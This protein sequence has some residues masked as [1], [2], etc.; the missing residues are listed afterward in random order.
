MLSNRVI[1]VCMGLLVGAAV[2]SCS[3]ALGPD[4]WSPKTYRLELSRY[5]R[6]TGALS[7]AWKK[8]QVKGQ[9][10]DSFFFAHESEKAVVTVVFTCGKYRDVPL[11]ILAEELAIP[12]GRKPEIIRAGFVRR[13]PREVYRLVARGPY[14][15]QKEATYKDLGHVYN[16]REDMIVDAYLIREHHCLVDVSLSAEP[17][18]YEQAL[19]DFDSYLDSLGVPA[20]RS[21]PAAGEG[22]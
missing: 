10:G 19:P 2:F 12:M 17:G 13:G 20:E 14:L 9:E 7:P 15:Y 3:C 4:P 22:G 18:F 5:T 11:P 21:V 6:D 8:Y 1:P 16:E